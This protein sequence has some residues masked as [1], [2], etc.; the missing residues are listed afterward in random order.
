MTFKNMFKRQHGK[1]SLGRLLK[2][3]L[4]PLHAFKMLNPVY[5]IKH[6]RDVARTVHNGKMSL[7]KRILG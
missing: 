4:N 3:G 6:V 1:P 2:Q 7:A 5:A